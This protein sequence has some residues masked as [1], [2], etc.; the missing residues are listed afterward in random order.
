MVKLL[1]T[2]KQIMEVKERYFEDIFRNI[3]Q[4]WARKFYLEYG[5]K[6]KTYIL[7]IGDDYGKVEDIVNI[8]YKTTYDDWDRMLVFVMY[9]KLTDYGLSK[10]LTGTRTLNIEEIPL[11]S[12]EEEYFIN[13]NYDGNELY[14]QKYKGLKNQ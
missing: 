5:N 7:S 1:V 4:L 9:S 8:G 3:E 13:L 12:F 11:E 14:L 2:N 10:L 6:S